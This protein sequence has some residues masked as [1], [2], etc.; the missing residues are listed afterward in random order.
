MKALIYPILLLLLL[1]SGFTYSQDTTARISNADIVTLRCEGT[2]ACSLEGVLDTKV[3]CTCNECMMVVTI[4]ETNSQGETDTAVYHLED[5]T[6]EVPLIEEFFNYESSLGEDWILQEIEMYKNG[7][8]IAVRFTYK[9]ENGETH[10]V[11]FAKAAGK[12]YRIT[13]DGECVCKEEYSFE[14]HSASCSCE[15]C[16]MTVEEVSNQ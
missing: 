6:L 16:V 1:L 2:C 7:D 9:D 13:C 10:T 4:T 15:D 8:D 3:N 12:T 14:T 11:M 5:A